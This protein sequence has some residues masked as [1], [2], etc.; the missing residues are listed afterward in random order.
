LQAVAAAVFPLVQVAVAA[1]FFM[2]PLQFY[3][4][5]KL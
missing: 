1:V 3:Q 4:V 5:I 2:Q